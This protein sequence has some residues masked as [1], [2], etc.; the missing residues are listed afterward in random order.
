[1]ELEKAEIRDLLK[2][3]ASTGWAKSTSSDGESPDSSGSETSNTEELQAWADATTAAVANSTENKEIAGVSSKEIEDK[4]QKIIDKIDLDGASEE[5]IELLKKNFSAILAKAGDNKESASRI[6]ALML[7]ITTVKNH[8]DLPWEGDLMLYKSALKTAN[9]IVSENKI[10]NLS[11]CILEGVPFLPVRWIKSVNQIA[12]TMA[13]HDPYTSHDEVERQRKQFSQ[14]QSSK[15]ARGQVITPRFSGGR[16]KAPG[17]LKRYANRGAVGP[18]Y[19]EIVE[20]WKKANS[21][22]TVEEL[23]VVFKRLN[24]TNREIVKIFKDAGVRIEKETFWR[25]FSM[26]PSS[27]GKRYTSVAELASLIYKHGFEKLILGELG[28]KLNESTIILDTLD[29]Q[30]LYSAFYKLASDTNERNKK[31]D[32]KDLVKYVEQWGK[33]IRRAPSKEDRRA[34][35]AGILDVMSDNTDEAGW[36]LLVQKIEELIYQ[37]K[38]DPAFAKKAV[39]NLRNGTILDESKYLL[40]THLMVECDMSWRDFSLKP[41]KIDENVIRISRLVAFGDRE[42]LAEEVFAALKVYLRTGSI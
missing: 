17:R 25:A 13:A 8:T 12:K 26:S 4:V 28:H 37:S 9:Q 36:G 21:P 33:E 24:F 1:M 42:I 41:N 15:S 40:M 10:I 16:S 2:T 7:V 31:Y 18:S 34:L 29:K 19:D 22:T 30:T 11:R 32:F 39:L 35:V 23:I 27:A 38:V 6:L 20:E 14:Q 3:A 5:S